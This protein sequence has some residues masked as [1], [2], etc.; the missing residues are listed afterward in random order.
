MLLK[1]WCQKV[2]Q[3]VF[4]VEENSGLAQPILIPA[5]GGKPPPAPEPPGD[6]EPP[7]APDPPGDP[8]P[9]P[10][11]WVEHWHGTLIANIA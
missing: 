2:P 11:H 4:V 1:V 8:E 9:P 5:R 7:P 10:Q 6:P 3:L